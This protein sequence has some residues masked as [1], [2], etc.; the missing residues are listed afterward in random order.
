[1]KKQI[2]LIAMLL[3]TGFGYVANAQVHVGVNINLQP[4]WGPVGYD[5]ANYYYFPDID[6]YYDVPNRTYTFFDH[7][8]WVTRPNLPPRFG[9]FDLYH[10]Y[11][12]VIN[13]PNPWMHAD[14]F[15][16]Q[17]GRFRGM[18]NQGVIRDS[19][20]DK[21]RANPGHPEHNQYHGD[22]HDDHHDDHDRR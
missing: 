11:K 17:Y 8:V 10:S 18:H 9:N 1:M 15:R 14:R 4:I 16:S 21:Y 5:Y 13:E 2:I 3:A 20:E 6:A 19:H 22:H 12:A 7:G